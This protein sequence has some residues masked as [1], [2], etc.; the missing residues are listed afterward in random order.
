MEFPHRTY[1]HYLCK[2]RG[3]QF[4]AKKN[5]ERLIS[6][7]YFQSYVADELFVPCCKEVCKDRELYK[8]TVN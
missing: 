2:G 6:L 7:F 8:V 1:K 4:A 3:M 5:C